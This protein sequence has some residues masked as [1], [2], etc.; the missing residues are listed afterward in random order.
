MSFARRAT[1]FT[2]QPSAISTPSRCNSWPKRC[3]GRVDTDRLHGVVL[4]ALLDMPIICQ[5]NSYGKISRYRLER[6]KQAQDGINTR[7]MRKRD[8]KWVIA[9]NH[10]SSRELP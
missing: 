4:G 2:R 1:F 6:P 7:L 10:V 9:L 5:D 3:Y 8:G